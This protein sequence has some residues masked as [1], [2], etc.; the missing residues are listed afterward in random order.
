MSS[1]GTS[2]RP[3]EPEEAQDVSPP[4][5]SSSQP[6]KRRGVER[7]N[8][9][10]EPEGHAALRFAEEEEGGGLFSVYVIA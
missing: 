10:A 7:V 5:A 6:S 4:H 2:K 8:P 3:C 1:R 9:P